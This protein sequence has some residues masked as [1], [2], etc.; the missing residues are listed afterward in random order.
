MSKAC[1][2]CGDSINADLEDSVSEGSVSENTESSYQI[3]YQNQQYPVCCLGCKAV[4]EFIISGEQTSNYYEL[5]ENTGDKVEPDLLESITQWEFYDDK[6]DFWGEKDSSSEDRDLYLDIGG[7]HCSACCWLIRNQIEKLAGVEAQSIDAATGVAVI[8]WQ[9]EK[10]QFSS[11]LETIARLGYRPSLLGDKINDDEQRNSELKRLV[12][13]G[14]GMMQVMMYSVALYAGEWDGMDPTY[15]KFLTWV[16]L[17]VTTPVLFYAG[18]PFIKNAL[19]S[20]KNFS[21]HMDIPI[22]LAICSAYTLSC[23][24]FFRGQGSVYFDSVVMFIF[25]I[26]IAR[27]IQ[28]RLQY[29]NM[30][31]QQAL[32]RMLPNFVNKV[33]DGSSSNDKIEKTSVP[34]SSIHIDEE[35]SIA[36]GEIVPVDAILLSEHAGIEESLLTG[37]SHLISKTKGTQLSAGSI[38]SAQAIHIKATSTSKNSTLSVLGQRLATNNLTKNVFQLQL[39][40]FAS[41]FVIS[42]LGLASLTLLYWTRESQFE[43]GLEAAL[44]VL[45]ISCPCALSL[46]IPASLAALSHSLHR[47][48]MHVMNSN[49]LIQFSRAKTILFDKTGTLTELSLSNK[50]IQTQAESEFN[51]Q[52]CLDL[53]VALEKNSIHPVARVFHSFE[54]PYTVDNFKEIKGQGVSGSINDCEYVFA[55]PAYLRTLGIQVPE[56]F[57]NNELH[58]ARKVENSH[59][60]YQL[61]ANIN[62]DQ[63]LRPNTQATIKALQDE[64]LDIQII[65]GDRDQS[66]KEVSSQLGI[67][68]YLSEQSSQQKYKHIEALQKQHI[69]AAVGDGIN[70]A[71]VLNKANISLSFT[72]ATHIAQASADVL[73]SGQSLAPVHQLYTSCKKLNRIVKTNISWAITYNIIFIPM[74]ALGYIQPWMAALGMSLSSLFVV[75]NASRLSQIQAPMSKTHTPKIDNTIYTEKVT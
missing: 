51:Q 34:L 30:K 11:I 53:I 5:R 46:A 40:R 37:E 1:F 65:S 72:N 12:V 63:H 22:A 54:T 48:G 26:S 3:E 67:E 17:F 55:Q 42:V 60:P 68:N 64:G 2:H 32:V 9:P 61:L 66:V 31:T 44:S 49:A 33:I 39:A 27:F 10:A 16:S 69:V 28:H 56:F 73:L 25:F 29:K 70:D 57:K 35:L 74:A 21:A 75:L 15:N 45:V 41:F 20:I 18:L 4:A 59:Q 71:E 19:M 62:L 36:T 8:K 6:P 52:Q 43:K 50:H 23:I 7:I 14:L 47:Q 58:L 13:A 24:N 38:N